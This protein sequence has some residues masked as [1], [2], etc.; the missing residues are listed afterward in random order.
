MSVEVYL[1]QAK[2]FE[3]L[4]YANKLQIGT[5]ILYDPDEEKK[6]EVV[7]EYMKSRNQVSIRTDELITHIE[8]ER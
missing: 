7:V 1:S 4:T 6:K 5:V 2:L 8:S 3:Q